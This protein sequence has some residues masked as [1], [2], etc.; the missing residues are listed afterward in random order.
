MRF[1]LLIKIPQ[2]SENGGIKKRGAAGRA[3][4]GLVI[5]APAQ[6]AGVP[7]AGV[8]AGYGGDVGRAD[9]YAGG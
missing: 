1:F 8:D 6:A 3:P 5:E 9:R 4:V 7:G 2:P